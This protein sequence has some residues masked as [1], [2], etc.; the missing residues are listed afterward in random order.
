[1]D[2]IGIYFGNKNEKPRPQTGLPQIF[3]T[4]TK[5]PGLNPGVPNI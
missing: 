5:T 1:M 4:Q 2:I 3:R